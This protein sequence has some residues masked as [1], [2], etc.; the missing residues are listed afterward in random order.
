MRV[1]LTSR[2]CSYKTFY[3]FFK[4]GGK[5]NGC[6][7]VLRAQSYEKAKYLAWERYGHEVAG[8]FSDSGRAEGKIAAFKLSRI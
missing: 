3:V 4:F 6:Y 7:T 1:P 2:Q 8:V 5:F